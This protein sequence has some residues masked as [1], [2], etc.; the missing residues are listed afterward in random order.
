MSGLKKKQKQMAKTLH[1]VQQSPELTPNIIPKG[2]AVEVLREVKHDDFHSG[3]GYIIYWEPKAYS[4]VVD[5]SV[6]DFAK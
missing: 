5:T 4:S 3:T 1:D 6:L 2:A